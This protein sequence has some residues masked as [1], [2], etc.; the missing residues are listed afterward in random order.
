MFEHI[1]IPVDFSEKNAEALDVAVKLAQQYR[2]RITL[3]HVIEPIEYEDD[4][5][6]AFYQTLEAKARTQMKSLVERITL[7]DTWVNEQVLIGHRV[8]CIIE[9]ITTHTVDLLV[10]SSHRLDVDQPSS[11]GGATLSYQLS[12]LCPCPVLLLK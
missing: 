11:K 12:I 8:P 1:L 4:E 2:A 5:I 3:L 6:R 9:Y 10:L 7:D